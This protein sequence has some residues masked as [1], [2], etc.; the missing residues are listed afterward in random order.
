MNGLINHVPENQAARETA[1][2][3]RLQ[4]YAQREPRT[5]HELVNQADEAAREAEAEARHAM[6]VVPLVLAADAIGAMIALW[7]LVKYGPQA[8]QWFAAQ[9]WWSG[10]AAAGLLVAVV[11]W[12]TVRG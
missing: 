10:F 12:R 6:R 9:P 8:W 2:K 1:L 5:L 11:G 7:A 4:A 3:L